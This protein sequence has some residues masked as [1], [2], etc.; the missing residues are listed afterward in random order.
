MNLTLDQ[1]RSLEAIATEG[2]FAAAARGLNKA[3]SAIS[4]DI[5]QLETN[6]GIPL[7]DRSGHRA[8]LTEQGQALL[9]E[10]RLLLARARELERLAESFREGWEPSLQVIIDGILPME[11]IMRVLKK[12]VDEGVPTQ[13]TTR[14][15]FLG[16]VQHRFERNEADLMLVKDFRK[17]EGLAILPLPTQESLLVASREHP[18]AVDP[19]AMLSRQDLHDHV[20]LTV[21]D[22]SNHSENLSRYLFG[23]P[24]VYYLSDFYTKLRALHLCLGFGWMPLHLIEDDLEHDRLRLLKLEEPTREA[25]TPFLVHPTH[26]PMG[27]AGHM[28][29]GLLQDH[30]PN[31]T[32]EID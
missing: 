30:F 14:V 25:F 1:I 11:P 32:G 10:G 16:G 6:L 2:S 22:S 28:F 7:F 18:L 3:Q 21:Q 12:M 29:L 31:G 15:E 17:H 8:V 9:R 13:L 27:P 26:K 19:E 4:Y 23:C 5:R 24:R 20:Q